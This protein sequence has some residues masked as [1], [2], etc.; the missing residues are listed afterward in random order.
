MAAENKESP[1]ISKEMWTDI[2]AP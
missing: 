2:Y 1:P